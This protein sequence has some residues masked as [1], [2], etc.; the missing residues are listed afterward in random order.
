LDC[1]EP[2]LRRALTDAV[3]NAVYIAAF[4]AVPAMTA[5]DMDRWRQDVYVL[6]REPVIAAILQTFPRN[7]RFVGRKDKV[8]FS[9]LG[10]LIGNAVPPKL[11]RTIGAEL[12]KVAATHQAKAIA[13]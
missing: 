3:M 9:T 13:R 6:Q 5:S 7:Y 4:K 1:L 12:L 11:A 8:Y 10:R 2:L